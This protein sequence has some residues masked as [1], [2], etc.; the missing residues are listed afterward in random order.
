MDGE[1]DCNYADVAQ[2]YLRPG[3]CTG[4]EVGKAEQEIGQQNDA[5]FVKRF[6]DF[7]EPRLKCPAMP[8]VAHLKHGEEGLEQELSPEVVF[9]DQDIEDESEFSE[10]EKTWL[11]HECPLQ[12]A[13]VHQVRS[14]KKDTESILK[15]FILSLG[16]LV[17]K[18][19]KEYEWNN[20]KSDKEDDGEDVRVLHQA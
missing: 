11:K 16:P 3:L 10:K 17:L 14:C 9:H 15:F 1:V 2:S 6:H 18:E 13:Q 12:F 4:Y 8:D 19:A 7:T 20:Y 5:D